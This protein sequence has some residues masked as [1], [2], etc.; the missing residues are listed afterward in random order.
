MLGPGALALLV[1]QKFLVRV[2]GA[3]RQGYLLCYGPGAKR[4]R[5]KMAWVP[6]SPSMTH[7][8]DVTFSND[9]ST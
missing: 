6:L 1:S 3:K 9:S 8:N 4:E 7:P 5:R 2:Q